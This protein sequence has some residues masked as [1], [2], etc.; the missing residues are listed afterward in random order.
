M[1]RKVTFHTV[2]IFLIFFIAPINFIVF[3]P[4]G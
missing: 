1:L 2:I 3:L 4:V